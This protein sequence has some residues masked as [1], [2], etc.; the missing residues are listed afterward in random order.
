[1]NKICKGCRYN[2][3]NFLTDC[4]DGD[5]DSHYECENANY[6]DDGYGGCKCTNYDKPMLSS[7]M[8]MMVADSLKSEYGYDEID[9]IEVSDNSLAVT[10]IDG[11]RYYMVVVSDVS[12]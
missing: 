4:D 1:M 3:D 12:E 11:H 2:N 7:D 9:K 5:G 8:A 10:A 6:I